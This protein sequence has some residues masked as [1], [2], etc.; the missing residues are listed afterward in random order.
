MLS[1]I[2]GTVSFPKSRTYHYYSLFAIP[3][4][5]ACVDLSVTEEGYSHPRPLV[6]YTYLF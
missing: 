4:A 6:R 3:Q 5:S 2:L 1:K